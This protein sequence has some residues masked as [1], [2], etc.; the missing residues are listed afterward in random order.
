MKEPLKYFLILLALIF[1]FQISADEIFGGFI[2]DDPYDVA[3]NEYDPSLSA[4]DGYDYSYDPTQVDDEESAEY[5]SQAAASQQ[6]E[7]AAISLLKQRF[8]DDNGQPSKIALL[9]PLDYTNLSLGKIVGGAMQQDLIQYGITTAKQEDYVIDSLT[10]DAFRTAK[11]RTRS[12]V[13]L[14]SVL[15]ADQFE[16]FLWDAKQPYQIYAYAEPI[17]DLNQE[18]FTVELAQYYGQVLIRRVLYLYLQNYYLDLP[19]LEKRPIIV[20][21]IPR[22]VASEKLVERANKDILSDIYASASVGAA[23]AQ[24]SAGKVWGSNVISASAAV[25]IWDQ[26]YFEL[27]LQ[28]FALTAGL[29]SIKYYFEALDSPFIFGVGIGGGIGYNKHTLEY[30]QVDDRIPLGR[31]VSMIAPSVAILFPIGDAYLKAETLVMLGSNK[32]NAIAFLPGLLLK[33]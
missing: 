28:S 13:L 12:N 1:S 8:T 7:Q 30:E 9:T 6:D 5:D 4:Q 10:L 23:F 18:N 31:A 32:Q 33:F 19:R 21:D 27:S 29:G 2:E 3:E 24:G 22:W 14:L 11:I 20:T 15:K 26:F 16:V 17:P 25:R